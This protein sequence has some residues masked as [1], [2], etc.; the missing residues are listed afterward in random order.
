MSTQLTPDDTTYTL[1]INEQQRR[2]IHAALACYI[3][4]G[5]DTEV[6]EFGDIVAI[7]LQDMLNPGGP[8]GPL[9]TTAINSFVL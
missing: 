6:N 1:L 8:V 4:E 5:F 7:S 2:V 9:S 3:S